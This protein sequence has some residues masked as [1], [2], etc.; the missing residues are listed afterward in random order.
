MGQPHLVPE[1]CALVVKVDQARNAQE[2]TQVKFQ[3]VS[4]LPDQC[5]QQQFVLLRKPTVVQS[6]VHLFGKI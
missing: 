2:G 6:C 4:V 3:Q 1:E 5:I